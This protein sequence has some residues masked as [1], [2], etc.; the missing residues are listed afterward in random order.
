[1]HNRGTLLVGG[2]L[3]LVA[4]FAWAAV[5]LGALRAPD[6]SAAPGWWG[7]YWRS[8]PAPRPPVDLSPWT[9]ESAVPGWPDQPV[10]RPLSPV[11]RAIAEAVG[12]GTLLPSERRAGP[13]VGALHLGLA[14]APAFL[15]AWAL[16][17]LAVLLPGGAL[18]LAGYWATQPAAFGTVSAGAHAA[19]FAFVH[20]AVWLAAGVPLYLA[21]LA[22]SAT[23]GVSAVVAD[24]LRYLPAVVVA[25]S[26]FFEL[27]QLKEGWLVAG[28]GVPPG[29]PC[30]ARVGYA[31]SLPRACRDAL[32]FL[33]S[34]AGLLVALTA[35]GTLGVAWAALIGLAV[36]AEQVLPHGARTA[37][38]VGAGLVLIG[39]VL[40]VR[41]TAPDDLRGAL[42]RGGPDGWTDTTTLVPLH[43]LTGHTDRVGALALS[44]D[45]RFLASGG[46]DRQVRLWDVRAGRELRVF[47]RGRLAAGEDSAVA[48]VAVARGGATVAAGY[49][50]GTV[51]LWQAATGRQLV[52]LAGPASAVAALAFAPTGRSVAVGHR[53]G[54]LALWTLPGGRAAWSVAGG[55][56]RIG[57]VAFAPDGR[58]LAAAGGDGDATLR[59]TAT[60][61][62]RRTLSPGYAVWC[63][64]FSPDGRLLA[65]GGPEAV[66]L[67]DA[68]TGDEVH[69]LRPSA[70]VPQVAFSPDGTELTSVGFD[71]VVQSWAVATGRPVRTARVPAA[72]EAVALSPR[73]FVLAVAEPPADPGN[74]SGSVRQDGRPVSAVGTVTLW[75]QPTERGVGP[76]R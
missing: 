13:V 59:D 44:H 2:V 9:H 64:A 4:A 10:T 51:T 54:T 24:H 19:L 20:A 66:T 56:A 17:V 27:S 72:V 71:G 49:D 41:P 55:R 76:G 33:R 47:G 42:A 31:G 18:R 69:R 14:G 62:V 50:D 35:G 38:W 8:W 37:R 75:G 11:E 43:R 68:A 45:G 12:A 6:A 5:L 23:A 53:D 67:W 1:V 70:L 61:E 36:F 52:V 22:L 25:A 15:A 3:A 16:L 40:A 46:W 57:G 29:V 58:T 65:G 39:A 26:G 60:G 48:A 74:A 7:D 73:A 30:P 32:G 63:V 34:S 21:H 28:R